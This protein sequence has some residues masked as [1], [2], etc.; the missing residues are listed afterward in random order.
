MTT[1]ATGAR[2]RTTP[3]QKRELFFLV[4]DEQGPK[5][6]V[7]EAARRVG[8]STATAYRLVHGVKMS[9]GRAVNTGVRGIQIPDP[10][11]LEE[12]GTD[13]RTALADFNLFGEMFFKLRPSYWRRDAA[14]RFVDALLDNTQ[15]TFIDMNVFPGAG[16]TTLIKVLCCWL[17]A[18]G[19]IKDPA[20]G[21]AIRIML[22][23]EVQKVA[24]HMLR[25]VRLGLELRRPFTMFDKGG[26]EWVEA[27]FCLAQEYGRFKPD[28]QLGEESLWSQDQILVAQLA[29][30]DVILKEPT[31]QVASKE[32]GFLGERVDAAF[33]DDLSTTKNSRNPAVAE[34]L[35][36]WTENE[37]EPRV[38][39]GGLF[40]HIGQRLSPLDLHRKRLDARIE[41]EK[42]EL[43]PLY[44]HVTYPA[45]RDDLCDSNHR[46]WDPETNSGCLTDADALPV[47]DW[48]AVRSKQEYRTVYQQED[49]DPAKILVQQIWLEGGVD[50]NGE[51][52]SGCYDRDRGFWEWPK[53]VGQ[54]VDY[55][56]LDPAAGNWWALEWWS[57]QPESRHNY[58]IEGRRAK[59]Q[60]G[61]FLD[62]NNSKQE[63][64]GWMHEIQVASILACHP[65]R[66]WIVESN[67]AHEYLQQFEHF[68]RWKQL[69]SMVSV[70]PHQTQKN[71]N[72]PDFGVE[73][74]L[75]GRY[76][77]GMKHLPKKQGVEAL[78][79][80]RQFE[81]E[82]TTYPFAE[83]DDTV[84]S[85]W[86]G[87][88]NLDKIIS[89]GRRSLN[90]NR[91]P[92]PDLKL[93]KYLREQY[94]QGDMGRPE[95]GR[96]G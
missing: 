29:G 60:A 72:D 39:K 57:V 13:P 24:R 87:E 58:L 94:K 63:F 30:V 73:A 71:K 48:M 40:G 5:V 42:G 21:R 38:E 92:D 4:F 8:I 90:E 20:A 70:I 83:T 69:F 33:W 51:F 86:M 85:D 16:K 25:A 31:V 62:W 1:A 76:R 15:R 79:F 44:K 43:V 75:P 11:R 55:A 56:T 49:A 59:I 74:L 61:T 52:S 95:G 17:I 34:N 26:Q 12:L 22:G 7:T 84:M 14:M 27:E 68:R 36:I 19:G 46:Q 89:I 77:T 10:R 66:V 93:P 54:L 32:M 2:P 67:A 81:K 64:S 96:S 47:K 3:E 91:T 65:I 45:H 28:V 23:A 88:I 35:N 50:S 78:N 18:G 9:D 41:N 82:L 6:A 53:G 37:A 80:L